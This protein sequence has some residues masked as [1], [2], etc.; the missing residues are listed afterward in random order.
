MSE[1]QTE[2]PKENNDKK[3]KE[4]VNEDTE[5]KAKT[6]ENNKER[7]NESKDSKQEEQQET[8]EWMAVWDANAQG[9]Y[10]WNTTTNE[11]TWENPSGYDDQTSSVSNNNPLDTLLDKIDSQ[12]KTTLDNDNNN[13]PYEHYFTENNNQEYATQAHFN[14]RTGRFTTN[15]DVE[16]LNPELFTIENRGT[17]QMKYYFDVDSYTEEYN[18]QKQVT[19]GKKRSLTRKEVEYF[20]K[21][22][23]EKKSKRARE[24]LLQ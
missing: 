11:T 9:Y 12:V 14:A 17:K 4:K 23:K 10:W 1:K 22:K 18:R 13:V 16:R 15:Q 20:K 2:I 19:T 5:L 8:S 3:G 7:S 24:W 21:A 6:D